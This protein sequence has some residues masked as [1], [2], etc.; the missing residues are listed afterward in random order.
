MA[1]QESSAT[2]EASIILEVRNLFQGEV[3]LQDQEERDTW[4]LVADDSGCIRW[5]ERE[6]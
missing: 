1:A 4:S 5:E 6:H 3:D 2:V